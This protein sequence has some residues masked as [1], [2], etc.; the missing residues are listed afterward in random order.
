MLVTIVSRREIPSKEIIKKLLGRERERGS[1]VIRKFY[2]SMFSSYKWE[3][4]T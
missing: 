3:N 1:F 4:D 2:N